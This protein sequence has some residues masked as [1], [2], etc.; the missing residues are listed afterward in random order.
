MNKAKVLIFGAGRSSVYLIK[1]LQKFLKKH[2]GSLTIVAKDF[3]ALPSGLKENHLTDLICSE[4][5]SIV[6][7][8]QVIVSDLV[9]SVLPAH[10]HIDIAKACLAFEKSLLTA[11][12]VSRELEHLQD[13]VS[14]KNLVFLNEMGLDPGLDHMSAM[15]LIDQI[16]KN[17]GQIKSYASYTGGLV[18]KSKDENSWNYKFTWN[19]K[20]VVIAGNG[21]AKFLRDYKI[22]EVPYKEVFKGSTRIAI[23]NASY[24]G[25]P[26]RNSLGYQHKYGL[27]E[28]SS[29]YR[30]TL[31]HEGFSEAWQAFVNLG[32]TNDTKPL[33]F[34]EDSSKRDFLNYFLGEDSVDVE[35]DFCE[36]IGIDSGHSIFKKFE[37]IGL[38]DANATRFLKQ[39]TSAEILLSILSESWKMMPSDKDLVVMKHE[40]IFEKEGNEYL[41]TSELEIL[42][43][44]S[45]YTAMAKT[46][47]LPLFEASKL[48]LNNDIKKVGVLTPTFESI[49]KPVLSNLESQ[50]IIF[51]EKIV[52]LSSITHVA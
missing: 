23:G 10:L 45:Y 46:V 9:I 47:G 38:F 18:E 50:G 12:Y 19:P 15:A 11:S 52:P 39:G 27:K 4:I 22:I 28:V 30:G 2:Q 5:N 43:E 49:Y 8:E 1:S 7:S 13:E 42:G 40:V 26:N 14:A 31:R 48:I 33:S 36:A 41:A 20:N 21:G 35:T 44:D 16:K 37:S 29:I 25:Y 17:Q 3:D 34:E 32:M 6:I 24:D 51:K